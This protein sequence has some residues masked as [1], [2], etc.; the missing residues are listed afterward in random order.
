MIRICPILVQVRDG[1]VAAVAPAVVAP[2]VPVNFPLGH[3]APLLAAPVPPA[4]AAG[5]PMVDGRGSGRRRH[6]VR[7]LD[8][9]G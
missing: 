8:E 6:Q 7:R 1:V 2:A 3:P 5:G 4:A 9:N